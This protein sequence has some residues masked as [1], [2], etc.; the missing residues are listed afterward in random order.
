MDEKEELAYLYIHGMLPKEQKLR[1]FELVRTEPEFTQLL[2]EELLMVRSLE[3]YKL[4]LDEGK[5]AE[6]YDRIQDKVALQ[7]SASWLSTIVR[8]VMRKTMPSIAY[9]TLIKVKGD[10]FT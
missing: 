1:V 4:R 6:L 5:K 7:G 3:L 9:L 8:S 2:T 10:V